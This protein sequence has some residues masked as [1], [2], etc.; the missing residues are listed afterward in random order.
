MNIII[1]G[2]DVATPD[3]K[4]LAKLSGAGRIERIDDGAFRL[5]EAASRAGV[6][7]FCEGEGTYGTILTRRL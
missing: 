6:A 7:E 1:Q 5:C 4:Q 3:L 2:R